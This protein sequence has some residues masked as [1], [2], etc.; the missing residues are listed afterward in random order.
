MSI[1]DEHDLAGRLDQTFQAITPR[2]AP[3]D[4]A[5]RQGRLI[6]V[7]RRLA[8]AAAGLVLIAAGLAIP[9]LLHQQA[10]QPVLNRL[11][12]HEV[13][14]VPAGPHSPA[15]LIASGTVDGRPWRLSTSKPGTVGG[16]RGSQCFTVLSTQDCGPV[17]HA[18]RA[19]PVNFSGTSAG[20]TD[21]E[22]GPVRAAVSYVTVQ[23]SDGTV[24]RLHPVSVYGLRYVAFA[25]PLLEPV[26]RITAYSA[27]GEVAAAIPFNDPAGGPT[28]VQWLRPG[29]RGLPRASGLIGS[30]GTG[31][32]AWS[33]TA[34]VGP[35]GECLDSHGNGG[36]ASACDVASAPLGAKVLASISGTSQLMVGAAAADV[37][38]VVITLAGGGN[39]RVP[40]VRVGELKFFVFALSRGQHAV[41]WLAYDAARHEVGSGPVRV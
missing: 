41:R 6:R 11:R 12:H 13:T 37:D 23:L 35:W 7:R 27:R 24:L 15:G 14:V 8:A 25:V 5:V 9:A 34:Y 17:D 30:G 32:R 18:D 26:S 10:T 19:D 22:Y 1:S 29:Q 31:A 3:V 20:A 21:V 33:V 38:H 39:I 40:A 36:G 4:W 28:V 2:P 16:Q